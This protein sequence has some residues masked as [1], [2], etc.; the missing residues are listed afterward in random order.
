MRIR[1]SV[2]ATVALYESLIRISCLGDYDTRQGTYA[3][4]FAP[5]NPPSPMEIAPAM[6]SASPPRTT[7]RVSPSDDKPAVR[8]NG[9][10]NPSESPMMASEIIRGLSSN[11]LRFRAGSSCRGRKP[12][13]C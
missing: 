1:F 8:A 3:S 11:R 4:L 6:S 5:I 9:T 2:E 10:V 7:K 12:S 13:Y